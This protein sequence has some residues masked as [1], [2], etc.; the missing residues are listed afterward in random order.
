MNRADR[1]KI[2]VKMVIKKMTLETYDPDRLD[3]TALRVLD[4]C[5]RLR[6]L[7]HTSRAEQLPAVDLHDKKALEWLEKLEDWLYRAEG[8]VRRAVHKNQGA[9]SA[10]KARTARES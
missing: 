10:R 4:L 9:K 6:Q 5:A 3:Q 1:W 7:A 2:H 8:E